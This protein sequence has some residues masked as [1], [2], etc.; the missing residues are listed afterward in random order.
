MKTEADSLKKIQIWKL[1]KLGFLK[2]YWA[3]GSLKWT[4]RSSGEESSV[5]INVMLSE[6]ERY[7][8]I[9]YTQTDED[10]NKKDFDY[11][12]P[13]TST[14][15]YF[16]GYRYWFTCPWYA[17]KIYCGRRAGVLYKAGNYFACRHCYNLSYASK[18]QSRN[19][20]SLIL[21][22][23][24]KRDEIA[25]KK[26]NLRVKFWKGKP[27]KR[28]MKLEEKEWRVMRR[29]YLSGQLLNKLGS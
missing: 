12:I 9:Y 14:P 2:E 11:K 6:S 25:E 20:F 1:K 10:G 13:I 15:C 16:G 23:L 29:I 7:L 21:D 18:N 24:F 26:Y 22:P 8:R 4:Y 17:N 28:Y 3:A 5:G 19:K 27:T